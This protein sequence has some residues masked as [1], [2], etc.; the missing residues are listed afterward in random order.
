MVDHFQI[1]AQSRL[2]VTPPFAGP[3]IGRGERQPDGVGSG[4]SAV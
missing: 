3:G 4:S 1:V 2:G